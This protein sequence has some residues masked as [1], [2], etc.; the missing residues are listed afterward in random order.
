MSITDKD[1]SYR[2]IITKAVCGKGRKFS[3][4]THTITPPH[5]PTSVLGVWLINHQYEAVKSDDGI[6]VVGTYD[7]NFWYSYD[8]NS[9]T[10]V[11]KET[12]SYVEAVPLSYLDPNHRKATAEVFAETTQEPSCVEANIVTSGNAVRIKVEREYKVEMVAETKVCVLVNENGID[13]LD[14]E[15]DFDFDYEGGDFEDLDPDLL[16]DDI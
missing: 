11:A 7:I 1:L 2:E 5:K 4:V 16:D 14:G 15:K 9:Q 3:Q 12:L 8:N 10:E 6:E 13:E